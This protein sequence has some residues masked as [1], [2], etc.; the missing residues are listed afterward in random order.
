[1]TTDNKTQRLGAADIVVSDVIF[2]RAS[3]QA[4]RTGLIGFVSARLY[5]RM[6]VHGYTVRR[7]LTGTL[8]VFPPERKDAAKRLRRVVEVG[9]EY[10]EQSV[11]RQILAA[12]A[13][14]G[15]LR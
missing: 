4:Q 11:E 8:R 10:D 13:A 7:T 15:V 9:D 6:R 14:Q 2:S 12:L 5:G 1:M 3:A